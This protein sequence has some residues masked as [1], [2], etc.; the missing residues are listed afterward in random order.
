MLHLGAQRSRRHLAVQVA[1]A[2]EIIERFVRHTLRQRLVL[3]A[4]AHGLA[5]ANGRRTAEHHEVK[6]RVGAQAIRAV[7]GDAGRLAH[8][9]QAGHDRIGIA[10]LQVHDLAIAVGRHAAHVVVAGGLHRYRLLRGVHARE[11]ARRLGDTRQALM[12]DLRVQMLDVEIDII[13]VGAAAAPLAD[14]DRHRAA[15]HVA[16][17]QVLGVRRIAL[18]EA[19]AVRV[20]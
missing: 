11:D 12:D 4:L 2:V 1:D 18:H 10:V 17:G 15:D 6:E 3:L 9:H 16:A 5:A 14:L 19:L 7:D 13:L 20:R 8:R